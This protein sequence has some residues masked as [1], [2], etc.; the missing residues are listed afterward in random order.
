MS[1]KERRKFDEQWNRF[2]I[3]YM[4]EEQKKPD[5]E[6]VRQGNMTAEGRLPAQKYLEAEATLAANSYIKEYKEDPILL[7]KTPKF[8]K[9][10]TLRCHK[11]G[12]ASKAA[13]HLVYCSVLLF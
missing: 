6:Q 4:K 10:P 12:C 8:N 7:E 5:K 2:L 1:E 11:S 13:N 9:A 3:A